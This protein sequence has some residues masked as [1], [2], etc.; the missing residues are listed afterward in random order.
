MTRYL[1]I[2]FATV[3][4]GLTCSISLGQGG[5]ASLYELGM[6]DQGMSAAGRAARANDASTAYGN[7]AGMGWLKQPEVLM[8]VGAGFFSS[9]PDFLTGAIERPNCSAPS[10]RRTSRRRSTSSGPSGSI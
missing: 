1:S 6:P 10:S 5:G 7:P 8:G 4:I 9:L 3:I 2:G